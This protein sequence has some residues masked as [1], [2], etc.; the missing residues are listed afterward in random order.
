LE[1]LWCLVL[2]AWCFVFAGCRQEMHD[3]PRHKPLHAS[4]FFNDG[5]S[6]RPLLTGTVPRGFLHT[7]DA[8]YEGLVGT[9]LVEKIPVAVT[10]Q[11]LE[12]G[13][14]R[15]NIYC[16]VC[17]DLNGEGN[18]MVVQRGFPRPP[19]FHI[20]R[21]RAAPAGHFY[22]VI[23]H[24]Y[25]VMYPYRSR[26]TPEDRWAI[27]AYIRALQLSRGADETVREVGDVRPV[28]PHPDPLPQGEGIA[29][30]HP[31]EF[32]DAPRESSALIY[33]KDWKQFS[34]SPHR[35]EGRG[36]GWESSTDS[37]SDETRQQNDPST[38]IP[39][40][41]EGR[42]KPI[43]ERGSLTRSNSDH[44]NALRLTEPRS[45]KVTP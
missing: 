16:S 3:Q 44:T 32:R 39:L 10:T 37:E 31:S 21:L 28:T 22:R 36:E 19:S 38:S 42:G 15:Y 29:S 41:V 24:G 9:N 40:P 23:T 14:E 2:G 35:R 27:T 45:K 34:L 33:E 25:G 7:N 18:G 12:R 43:T 5:M 6:A 20:E 17:H 11:L 26:V 4:S 8:F 13:R 1:I 30:A